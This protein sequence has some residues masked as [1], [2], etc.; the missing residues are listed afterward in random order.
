MGIR[1][2]SNRAL[3]SGDNPT[4]AGRI[5][6][7]DG[8]ATHLFPYRRGRFQV[9]SA[10]TY[11]TWSDKDQW[12]H[13]FRRQSFTNNGI[14]GTD[15]PMSGIPSEK[16][17]VEQAGEDLFNYAIERDDIKWLMAQL[18]REA[19]VKP[20]TVEYELQILKIVSVGWAISYYLEGT[21][22]RKNRIMELYWR[23]INEFSK[24]LSET[25]GLMIGQDIDYF[26]TL[27]SRL[28]L[29]VEAM[30][31]D[32]NATDPAVLIGP[33]FARACGNEDDI[34]TSMTGTKLFA[35]AIVRVRQYLE[36][37]KLR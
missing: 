1:S 8:S 10:T 5:A 27:K 20:A 9:F 19:D 6:V 25:T 29:Y 16:S 7:G 21:P 3:Y 33:A 22:G 2:L 14:L 35:N 28:D 37:V 23:A 36:A 4:D 12:G 13:G 11:N 15:S 24:Q 30:S 32:P 18:P 17:P 34:F 31:G 26:E